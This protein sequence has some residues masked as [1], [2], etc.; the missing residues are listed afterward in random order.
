MFRKLILNPNSASLSLFLSSAYLTALINSSIAMEFC[1]KY[2]THQLLNVETL[3]SFM[4]SGAP[5]AT[6]HVNTD[7]LYL[8]GSFS[9]NRDSSFDKNREHVH[10]LKD[11]N[12]LC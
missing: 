11:L 10:V 8:R 3:L 1:F 7:Y 12:L 6:G 4:K 2:L 9:E 5:I